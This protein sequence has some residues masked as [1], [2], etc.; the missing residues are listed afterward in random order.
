MYNAPRTRPEG[1]PGRSQQKFLDWDSDF[2]LVEAWK[3]E[4]YAV[5]FRHIDFCPLA[6]CLLTYLA[7][8]SHQINNTQVKATAEFEK[9]FF[10]PTLGCYVIKS[11]KYI[12]KSILKLRTEV[13]MFFSLFISLVLP[14]SFF[15]KIK[16]IN[17]NKLEC[18]DL[19]RFNE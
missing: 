7:Q 8:C 15:D 17:Q 11:K 5:L 14:V 1:Q 19:I 12:F 10:K 2:C 18:F 6:L 16:N 4:N 9:G 3:V 13:S